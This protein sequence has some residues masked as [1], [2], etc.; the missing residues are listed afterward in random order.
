[1]F[2]CEASRRSKD[3]ADDDVTTAAVDETKG[4]VATVVDAIT[5]PFSAP[6][7]GP[8]DPC[9]DYESAKKCG[10]HDGCTWCE[11]KWAAGQCFSEVG[12]WWVGPG[13][14]GTRRA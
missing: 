10:R 9:T 4:W 5:A 7:P 13:S 12:G 1:V 8:S 14:S 11:G 2:S 6:E 3:D